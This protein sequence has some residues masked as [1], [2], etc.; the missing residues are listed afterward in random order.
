[1]LRFIMTLHDIDYKPLIYDGYISLFENIVIPNDKINN[2]FIA[3][4]KKGN[5]EIAKYIVNNYGVADIDVHANKDEIFRLSCLCGYLNL[6]Q[7]VI[8]TFDDINIHV[9]DDYAFRLSCRNGHLNVAQWLINTFN[10]INIHANNDDAFRL[11]CG[12]GYLNVAQWLIN[13]F[14]DI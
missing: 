13:T 2:I 5:L 3:A 1:M 7:W 10:D 6:V 14:N 12:N 4:C 11:S 8:G 9:N